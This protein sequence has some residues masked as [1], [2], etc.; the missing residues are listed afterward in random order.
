MWILPTYIWGLPTVKLPSL[1]HRVM[2]LDAHCNS[3]I[4]HVY[5]LAVELSKALTAKQAIFECNVSQIKPVKLKATPVYSLSNNY[6]LHKLICCIAFIGGYN[7][8]LRKS[9]NRI[10]FVLDMGHYQF[11]YCPGKSLTVGNRVVKTVHFLE[12]VNRSKKDWNRESWLCVAF[13]PQLAAFT[14]P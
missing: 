9:W 7:G 1:G 11:R 4:W 14:T 10:C 2:T 8:I 13:Y 6:R 12:P 3:Q 5:S